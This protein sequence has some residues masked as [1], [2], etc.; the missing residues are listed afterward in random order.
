MSGPF[1]SGALQFFS[2]GDTGFYPLS[3]GQSLRF[4]AG[5]SAFLSRTTGSATNTFTF[6]TWLKRGN[7][8]AGDY[9][10]IFASGASGLAIG[11]S[12]DATLAD[13]LYIYDGSSTQAADP[14]IRDGGAW[15]HILLSSNS[16]T[17][18]LYINGESVK[19]SIS[20]A[21][22]ST[23]SGVTRV[24]RYGNGNFYLDAY[25][26]ET[27]LVTGSALTP[28]S[29]GETKNDIWVAKAYTG[30]HGDDGF[31]LTYADSSDI[32][33]D[34]S[35][36]NHDLTNTNLTASDVVV[37]SPTNNFCVFNALNNSL[38]LSEGNLKASEATSSAGTGVMGTFAIDIA[39]STKFYFE[40]L[41]VDGEFLFGIA[42]VTTLSSDVNR[43]GALGYFK[44]GRKFDGTTGTSYSSAFSNGDVIGVSVGGGQIEFFRDTGS[45]VVSLGVAFSGK[46]GLFVPVAIET[47]ASSTNAIL[48]CGQDSTFAGQ[49]SAGSNSDANG[50]G[51]FHYSVP[52]G[53]LAL[54]S[55]NLPDPGIDPNNNETPDQYF[56]TTL[57]TGNSSTQSI[58][59]LQFQP[60]FVWLKS[61]TLVISHGLFDVI[62]GTSTAGSDSKAIG[63]NRTETEGNGN[64]VLSAFNSDG[65][66]LDQGSS[67]NTN[68]QHT[69]TNKSGE[70]YVAWT[71]RAGGSGVSNGNGSI[72]S[73]VSVNT[74]AGFSIVSYTGTNAT[75]ATVGHGLSKTP[76]WVFLKN[77]DSAQNWP[78]AHVSLSSVNH[79]LLMDSTLGEASA[80]TRLVI[81][82]ASTF[83]VGDSADLDITN[84]LDD[85]YIAYCWHSVDGYSKF[86]KYKGN[87]DPNGTFVFIGFRP[88]WIMIKRFDASG[89]SWNIVD[90]KRDT[91]NGAK[92]LLKADE[93]LAEASATNGVDLL[94]NGFKL[95]DNIGNYNT[96]GADYIYMA[97]AD[98]PFKYANAR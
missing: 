55:S 2:G 71:W 75:S 83:T 90:N 78:T 58:T 44:D 8:S 52:S 65:F 86:G 7:I 17:G 42:P 63:T 27:H 9:Q 23:S 48:N 59:G 20:V 1:G 96:S 45:G 51:L 22:L 69:I 93:S 14:L 81:G 54:C 29:F 72:S 94:S 41:F 67:G 95:R 80:G 68:L 13:K 70:T 64:G 88:A 46:T 36:E 92:K 61:R 34:S 43:T 12:S 57:Y 25:L 37:D 74:E 3:I 11:K 40:F 97:F 33:N 26:A 62:R 6:S 98:Q 82:N 84:R 35:G 18:V 49:K 53:N 85:K 77:R 32:G 91:F 24:G 15:Y 5:D 19:T 4:N 10:Y 28:S 73:T 56:D 87:G 39:S 60:D 79:I 30:S 38:T 16:G 66:T 47:S 31:K 89:E 21:S 50:I 76:E